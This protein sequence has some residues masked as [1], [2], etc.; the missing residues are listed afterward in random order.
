MKKGLRRRP[1]C[2]KACSTK[3][4]GTTVAAKDTLGNRIQTRENFNIIFN[5]YMIGCQ[6]LSYT[7][8]DK[9][10]GSNYFSFVSAFHGL[11]I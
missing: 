10:F 1:L 8:V 7:T 9:S 5:V 11:E 2:A 4:I 6:I 3:V